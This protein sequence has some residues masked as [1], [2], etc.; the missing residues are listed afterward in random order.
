VGWLPLSKKVG[1]ERWGLICFDDA[2]KHVCGTNGI[3]NNA[4]RFLF[5]D[6][7]V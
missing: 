3:E 6:T 5:F 7:L 2:L 4:L 1:I